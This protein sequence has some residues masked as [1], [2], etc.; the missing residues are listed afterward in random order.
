MTRYSFHHFTDPNAVLK[1][2]FRVCNKGGKILIADTALPEE[3]VDACN[4][5]E[6]LRA[7]S[8]TRAL[9]LETVPH[10]GTD[11]AV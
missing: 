5:M 9:S 7:P 10:P 8:R 4:H 6:K 3:T 11:I 1:V 2:M